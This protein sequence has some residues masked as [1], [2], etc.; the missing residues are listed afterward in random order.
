[1]IINPNSG[2]ASD[3]LLDPNYQRELPKL[4][5][6]GNVRTIG[7]VKIGWTTR[8][9]NLVLDEVSAYASWSEN[10]N[11]DYAMNGIFYDETPNNYSADGQAYMTLINEFA[12]RQ[13][14][15]RSTNYVSSFSIPLTLDR[16][17]PRLD[18]Q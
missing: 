11:A 5:A 4:N 7:Y 2:P 18:S 9:I 1:V 16:T 17:Q 3:T 12:K 14:G 8:D 10:K 13:D 6:K 15:F